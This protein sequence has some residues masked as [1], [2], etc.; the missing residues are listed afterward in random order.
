ME[1]KIILSIS[2]ESFKKSVK[3]NFNKLSKLLY[4]IF[5]I[6]ISIIFFMRINFILIKK[7]N[8]SDKKKNYDKY[9]DNKQNICENLNSFYNEN[10]EKRIKITDV[11]FHGKKYNMY[12]YKH[13]DRVSESIIK[14]KKWEDKESKN[15]LYALNY[16]SNKKNLKYEDIYIMDIGANIGWYSILFGK[17]GFKVISFEPTK[18]NNYILNKNFCLNKEINI[19]IINKGLYNKEEHCEIHNHIGN[20][21]NGGVVC[22]KSKNLGNNNEKEIILT[23]LSNY[24]PLLSDKNLVLIKI[25]IEGSEGKAFE[26]GIELITKYHVPFIFLEFTPKSLKGHNTDPKRFL[27]LFID[28][29]YKISFL[30][31][32]DKKYYSIED[33]L[34]RAKN[35]INLYIV[36]SKILD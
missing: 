29:G 12:V 2:E 6:E 34:K 16:Y 7:V 28:N 36:Y 18:I 13:S 21:G 22:D 26:G 14:K 30:K 1:E 17:Y 10:Y 32:I 25:D 27:Q 3:E 31:F 4:C 15:Q 9:L 11:N 20:E 35:Q 33:I 8:K 23:K 5:L 24:I 19:T